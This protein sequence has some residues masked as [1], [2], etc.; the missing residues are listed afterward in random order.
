MVDVDAV[1]LNH[2]RVGSIDPFIDESLSLRSV[3]QW[4][5]QSGKKL[6]VDTGV[7]KHSCPGIIRLQLLTNLFF[8]PSDS[9]ISIAISGIF[10]GNVGP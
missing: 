8:G 6:Y 5:N 2:H 10:G 3:I 9:S 7:A 1:L 4:G